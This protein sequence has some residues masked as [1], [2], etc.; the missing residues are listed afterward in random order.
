MDEQFRRTLTRSFK[1]LGQTMQAHPLVATGVLV[2]GV[3]LLLGCLIEPG[4]FTIDEANYMMSLH[5]LREGGLLVPDV[6]DLPASREMLY[7]DPSA[8]FFTETPRLLASPVPPWY[9]WLAYPFAWGGVWGL[10]LLNLL[11]CLGSLWLIF[12]RL[13]RLT[14][15]R[16]MAALSVAVC[17]GGT[18]LAEYAFGV[19]PHGLSTLLCLAGYMLCLP[20]DS[21]SPGKR[22]GV[23][24][25][26]ICG[27]LL[28][29][30]AAGVR[31]QNVAFAGLV[32]VAAWITRSERWRRA[33]GMALGMA[34]PLLGAAM[35]NG[36]RSDSWNPISKPGS[37]YATL[38]A[39][40]AV[41]QGELGTAVREMAVSFMSRVVDYA[42]VYPRPIGFLPSHPPVHG[43]IL[44]GGVVKKAWLQS[45]PWML[46][47]AAL[48]L[49]G[50]RPLKTLR[51]QG[52]P[53]RRE[54]TALAVMLGGVIALFA[55]AGP[56]RFD[57]LGYNQRYFIELLPLAS[58]AFV[59][60]CGGMV[61]RNLRPCLLAFLLTMLALMVGLQ[62]VPVSCVARQVAISKLPILLAVATALATLAARSR[63]RAR[64]P[65]ACLLGVAL[66][67]ACGIHFFEE[68]P[69]SRAVRNH[70]GNYCRQIA[71]AI[72]PAGA[73]TM[74][75]AHW[76]MS[77]LLAPLELSH[78]GLVI[79]D[80][81]MDRGA[82]TPALVE[83][84]LTSGRR[85]A[86][87][88][89]NMPTDLVARISHGRPTRWLL[90][91]DP[92]M[93]GVGLLELGPRAVES[94][95]PVPVPAP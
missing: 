35:M 79:V 6:V 67:W 63:S 11:A 66:G 15:S 42:F 10:M 37:G 56:G 86:V 5:A 80:P 38:A 84:A 7:S 54:L 57:G 75:V 68:L 14:G 41:G 36:A 13:E 59:L 12:R 60:T 78:P 61:W 50:I 88:L 31:Y 82:D 22:K 44:C 27:G 55:L 20:L 16:R 87:V 71:G 62:H 46:V 85:V 73:P 30:L 92:A 76:W 53:R 45:C 39:A 21:S 9:A 1:G 23:L 19:W 43:I 4:I 28:L 93:G 34:L 90:Q 95:T 48:M 32:L 77:T 81:R 26:A 51:L 33:L 24:P 74:L 70:Q 52:T 2:A 83:A 47:V 64:L 25:G 72:T 40:N 58:M 17:A 89:N 3:V 69:A 29:G 8:P 18:Y 49:L 65:A 91:G 94:A